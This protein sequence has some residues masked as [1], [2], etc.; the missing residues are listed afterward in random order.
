MRAIVQPSGPLATEAFLAEQRTIERLAKLASLTVDGAGEAAGAAAAAE[1]IGA[2]AH[3]VLPDGSSVFVPLAD[4]IDVRKECE[5]LGKERD[6]LD[7]QLE[8]LAAKLANEQFIARAPA[9]VVERERAK[10]QSWREQRDALQ[11]KLSA[12]G[13]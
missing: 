13:C 3:A 7:R 6:R 9:E 10:E 5:R 2:G 12:L 1:T 4:A 8:T 11:A